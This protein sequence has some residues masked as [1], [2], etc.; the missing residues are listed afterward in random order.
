MHNPQFFLLLQA[1][2]FAPT[3]FNYLSNELTH[4]YTKQPPQANNK[5]EK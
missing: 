1:L 3:E 5:L 4:K 2:L